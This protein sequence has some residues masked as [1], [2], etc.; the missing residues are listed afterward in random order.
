[1]LVVPQ[2]AMA[3]QEYTQDYTQFTQHG[4]SQSQLFL[5]E[6][7]RHAPPSIALP[8]PPSAWGKLIPS[9]PL[10]SPIDLEVRPPVTQL[11]KPTFTFLN[12]H[13]HP[14]DTFNCYT[15]GRSKSCDITPPKSD[16]GKSA[17]GD[18]G[19]VHT[20]LSN[21]HC[22]IFCMLST[23][24]NTMEV[25]VEDSS[26]NGTVINRTTRLRRGERRLLNTGDEIGL[27]NENSLGKVGRGERRGVMQCYEFTFINV[28]QQLTPSVAKC[29]P[30]LLVAKKTNAA[31]TEKTNTVCSTTT[32]TTT[33]TSIMSPKAMPPP[34][35]PPSQLF[36]PTTPNSP[37]RVGTGS[38]MVATNGGRSAR[39][40][41]GGMPVGQMRT[42]DRRIEEWY[43]VRNC[44]G[45]GT[46]GEV[47]KCINRQSGKQFAVK[48]LSL[49]RFTGNLSKGLSVDELRGE[50]EM[51][52]ALDHPYI[53]KLE[54]VFTSDT[55]I[56][57]VME[58][59]HGG[60]LFD[61]IVLRGR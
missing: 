42:F 48:I 33:T 27:V 56:Y 58:L 7:T 52:R 20:L 23:L 8:P 10:L 11:E 44:I 41:P 14:G 59:L 1:M 18:A 43:D 22:R 46:C 6:P 5:D 3:S 19:W 16:E 47:R 2:E 35:A 36:P 24:E 51:L 29:G 31:A 26:A 54:D 21:T 57:L 55:A 60:D 61:R 50:A 17:S 12:L 39:Q 53:V 13:L 9:N 32:S 28:W 30:V 38:A 45:S 40:R 49:Q 37:Q 34:S 4:D 25:F 15:I